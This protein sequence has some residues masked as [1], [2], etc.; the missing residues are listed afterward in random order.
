MRVSDLET[1]V[2]S[3]V[4]TLPSPSRY[5]AIMLERHELL[6]L[7]AQ[8]GNCFVE[9]LWPRLRVS[10]MCLKSEEEMRISVGVTKWGN[11]F[12]SDG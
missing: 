6:R 3:L 11:L 1:A 12:F 10:M 8:E 9:A 5:P 2:I 7:N 4:S